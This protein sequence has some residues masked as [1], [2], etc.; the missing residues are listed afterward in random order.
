MNSSL[1]A[2]NFGAPRLARPRRIRW[3]LRTGA[4]LTVIG[5]TRLVRTVRTR[6]RPVLAATGALLMV[7]GIVL[8]SGM[9]LVPGMLVLLFAL[10]K[11]AGASDCR[12]ATQLTAAHWTPDG[13][14]RVILTTRQT[15]LP[16]FQAGRAAAMCSN[17]A[18]L[19]LTLTDPKNGPELASNDLQWTCMRLVC[20]Q[21]ARG[22]S[23]L[24][25]TGQTPNAILRPFEQSLPGLDCQALKY[26][27]TPLEALSHS[28][29]A[30][31]RIASGITRH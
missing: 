13:A 19:H 21:K 30:T 18:D 17:Q 29:R 15:S 1:P 24:S 28:D 31:L 6:W 26:Q 11:G 9:T 3:W 7:V 4:L 22:S 5:A 2:G 25:S 20:I 14:S 23:P 10:L 8:P 12:D 16:T 27:S